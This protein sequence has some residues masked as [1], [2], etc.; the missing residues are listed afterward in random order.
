[1]GRN[2]IC[3]VLRNEGYQVSEAADGAE[4]LGLAQAQRFDLVVSDF[5][6]PKLDGFKLLAQLHSRYPRMP[7]ILIS[8]Y[9]AADSGQAILQET[10]KFI[11]KPFELET[12]RST[13]QRLVLPV[14][15]VWLNYG[16]F[17]FLA[18]SS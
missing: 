9:M 4:A 6:M 16:W 11:P 5:V 8:A 2:L 3:E 18:C 14:L 15:S 17:S 13:V 10:A 7:V 12:L 1:L